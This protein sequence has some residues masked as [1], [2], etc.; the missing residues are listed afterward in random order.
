MRKSTTAKDRLEF[1]NY[2]YD[3]YLKSLIQIGKHDPVDKR[4]T[5]H[6]RVRQQW[7]DN[8]PEKYEE[9]KEKEQKIMFLPTFVQGF[10]DMHHDADNRNRNFEEKW[11]FPIDI[12]M[13][14]ENSVA[15]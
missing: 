3:P 10:D 8:N 1:P 14:D 15:K 11:G 5:P 4:W 7:R 12:F 6:H 13:F 9:I 2:F